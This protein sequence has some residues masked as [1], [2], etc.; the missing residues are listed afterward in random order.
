M[1]P[2]YS[3]KDRSTIVWRFINAR[4]QGKAP[5]TDFKPITRYLNDKT[6]KLLHNLAPSGTR[7]VNSGRLEF[8]TVTYYNNNDAEEYFNWLISIVTGAV[9][10]SKDTTKEAIEQLFMFIF[11]LRDK[12][13]LNPEF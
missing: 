1:T 11:V 10:A 8:R 6:I 4:G 13:T 5:I 2:M 3:D 9:E 7:M 12:M